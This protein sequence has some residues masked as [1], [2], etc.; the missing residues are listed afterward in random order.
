MVLGIPFYYFI[1][2]HIDA[3][4]ESSYVTTPIQKDTSEDFLRKYLDMLSIKILQMKKDDMV[5][6]KQ[7]FLSF[8]NRQKSKDAEDIKNVGA[9]KKGEYYK[10]GDDRLGPYID[11][12]NELLLGLSKDQEYTYWSN[13]YFEILLKSR[14][15]KREAN[16]A[17][18]LQAYANIG[19]IHNKYRVIAIVME[20]CSKKLGFLENYAHYRLKKL[21]EESLFTEE[22]EQDKQLDRI[23]EFE[24]QSNVFVNQISKVALAKRKIF[25]EL[26]SEQPNLNNLN[27]YSNI[28]TENKDQVSKTYDILMKLSENNIKTLELYGGYLLDIENNIKEASKIYD[29]MIYI[30]R[31]KKKKMKKM[32]LESENVAIIVMSVLYKERGKVVGVNTE[33]CKLFRYSKGE[34]VN[35]PIEKFMPKFYSIH[36]KDFM[37]R[38]LR[39]GTSKILGNKRRIFILNKQNFIQSC[40]LFVKVMSSIDEG[41]HIVGFLNSKELQSDF[42]E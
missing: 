18:F 31:D 20:L 1:S 27:K 38:F 41:F 35:Q 39:H 29:R 13:L 36:H 30:M 19:L 7:A 37:A 26:T 40:M 17:I 33:A 16:H 3:N 9:G 25:K 4:I 22:D 21:V 12:S 23:V 8:Y 42:S 28:I 14:R 34:M 10:F 11:F 15:M 32:N 2:R 24:K 5:D 6:F